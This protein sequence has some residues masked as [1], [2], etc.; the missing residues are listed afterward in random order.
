MGVA[1]LEEAI[2]QPTPIFVVLPDAPYRI[3]VGAVFSYYE[4]AVPAGERMTDEEWQ[5]M[6]EA[7]TNPPSPEWTGM[8]MAP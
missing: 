7:G 5:A 4:F 8:F 6:V 1:A 3:A 2:G